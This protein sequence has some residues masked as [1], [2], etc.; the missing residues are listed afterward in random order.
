MSS[1]KKLAHSSLRDASISSADG[2]CPKSAH[3]PHND[4][5]GEGLF[6]KSRS[7]SGAIC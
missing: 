3:K 6:I 2:A 5:R 7:I 4:L 1:R